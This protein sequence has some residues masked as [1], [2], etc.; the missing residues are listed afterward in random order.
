LSL[1]EI[2]PPPDALA[3]RVKSVEARELEASEVV[4]FDPPPSDLAVPASSPL[5]EPLKDPYTAPAIDPTALSERRRK[6]HH[7]FR[8]RLAQLFCVAS[9]AGTLASVLFIALAD[10]RLGRIAATAALAS[11]AVAIFLA[12]GTRLT[13]RVLG[14]AATSSILAALAFAFVW[15]APRSWFEDASPDQR[16]RDLLQPPARKSAAPTPKPGSE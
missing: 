5:T 11:G 2:N 16:Q 3:R 10:G 9:I 15:V 13:T 8:Y 14:Y 4:V 7:Q 6:H 12:W 1:E